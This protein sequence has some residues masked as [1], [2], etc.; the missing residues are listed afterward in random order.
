MRVLRWLTVVLATSLVALGGAIAVSAKTAPLTEAQARSLGFSVAGLQ[1]LDAGMQA[2]IDNKQLSGAVTML[3][4]HGEVV[5]QK[6]Y[7]YQ[8]IAAGTRMREDTIFRIYS[9]TK[10]VV[11]VAMMMLY[12]EGKWQP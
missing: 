5:Q 9:M 1:Q 12:E 6:A 7:G 4:R 8:N 2:F 3:V 11:G 10:P